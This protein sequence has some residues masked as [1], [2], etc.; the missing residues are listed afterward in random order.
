MV[1]A[2]CHAMPQQSRDALLSSYKLMI[3]GWKDIERYPPEAL[4]AMEKGCREGAEALRA[5][6]R[7]LCPELER[8]E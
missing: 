7:A 1:L 6:G 5:A 8:P 4:A 2:R 3:E